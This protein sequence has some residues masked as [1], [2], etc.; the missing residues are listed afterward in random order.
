[1][2]RWKSSDSINMRNAYEARER[3]ECAILLFPTR[4]RIVAWKY[5]EMITRTSLTFINFK[6]RSNRRKVLP[7][8][9]WKIL[10]RPRFIIRLAECRNAPWPIHCNIISVIESGFITLIKRTARRRWI[11]PWDH[12]VI[13]L[14]NKADVVNA[15]SNALHN[16]Y[17]LFVGSWS[18]HADNTYIYRGV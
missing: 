13:I 14:Q 10:H 6:N 18:G 4:K 17:Y 1:M 16:L 3:K 15:L 11:E 12:N 8:D 9:Q 5:L 7:K 2:F